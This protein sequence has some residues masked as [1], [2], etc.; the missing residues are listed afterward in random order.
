MIIPAKNGD[1]NASPSTSSIDESKPN[2]SETLG[3]DHHQCAG[4]NIKWSS[5]RSL[6]HSEAALNDSFVKV[7]NTSATEFV[8]WRFFVFYRQYFIQPVRKGEDMFT[9]GI[10]A[11]RAVEDTRKD[12]LEE[13][14]WMEVKKEIEKARSTF[15][16][17]KARLMKR[18]SV[19]QTIKDISKER[20]IPA[21]VLFE[22]VRLLGYKYQYPFATYTFGAMLNSDEKLAAN[23]LLHDLKLFSKNPQWL[24][25][26]GRMGQDIF[27][28][29]KQCRL[30]H[31]ACLEK[32]GICRNTVAWT[33]SANEI[34]KRY[35]LSL[36]ESKPG[37]NSSLQSSQARTSDPSNIHAPHRKKR[38]TRNL[39]GQ[40]F[41][42]PEYAHRP[43]AQISPK[44]G[45]DLDPLSNRNHGFAID[46]ALRPD[47]PA[48]CEDPQFAEWVIECPETG[49]ETQMNQFTTPAEQNAFEHHSLTDSPKLKVRDFAIDISIR[50]ESRAWIDGPRFAKWTIR[51]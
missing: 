28:A 13:V 31:F 38:T 30:M 10:D 42:I 2:S 27:E 48:W 34:S 49:E 25:P 46:I 21:S 1:T 9:W 47:S 35:S 26:R 7:F 24:G 3:Y 23:V 8:P 43:I 39:I 6:G 32:R 37:N 12:S 5:Y 16:G 41:H 20:C 40:T 44:S 15:A 19:R 17:C 18:K 33:L 11:I 45:E 29:L 14:N 36:L 51:Y 50:P 22:V 4:H